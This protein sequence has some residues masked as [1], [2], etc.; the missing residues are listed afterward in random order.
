M[1]AADQTADTTEKK[2]ESL[3]ISKNEEE[4]ANGSDN[5]SGDENTAQAGDGEAKKKKKNKKRNKKKKKKGL[6]AA[7]QSDT[8]SVPVSQLFPNNSYPEGEICEYVDDNRYRT[9]SEEMR[10]KDRLNEQQIFD[11]RRSAEVHREVRQHVQKHIKP[12]M[13]LTTIAEMIE[14]GTRSLVE[15][16]GFDAG[17]GFPTGLS[18]NHCAAHFTPNAGDHVVIQQDDVLK[19][20]FGVHVNG[21]IID[22]AFT[23]SWNDRYDPLLAAVKDATNTGIREAGIDVR[24]GDIGAAI[25]EV[26]ESYEI[27]L[28]GKTIPIKPI[29]NLCGH[30]IG[31]YVIHSGKSV[32]IVA[33]NDQTRMEEGELFAIETFGSTGT[34][35]V[36]E[37]GVC[38][39]Y[40]KSEGSFAS[41]RIP[42]AKKLLQ[43]ITKNFGTLP[44]C[45][46]YID[47]LGE[48]HYYLGLKTLVDSGIVMAYPPLCDVKGSYTAQFEHTLLLRPNVKEVLSRGEDY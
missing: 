24:L 5:D 15:A 14:N 28:D 39:H 47:R 9:T 32:P 36:D 6:G 11:L 42:S 7:G 23:M 16:N 35:H 29:R 4:A 13:D 1:G 34:G 22:S 43:T 2:L 17:I 41:P 3:S 19:V 46:R 30:N 38:S 12:G 10:A 26:M 40:A 33:N 31:P 8:L 27:E 21:H 45:R 37:E 25:Q 18:L 44:F 20:D 48:S